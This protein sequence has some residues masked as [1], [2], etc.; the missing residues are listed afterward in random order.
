MGRNLATSRCG[1]CGHET[2]DLAYRAA[3][4]CPSHK[5]LANGY[6]WRK[7]QFLEEADVPYAFAGEHRLP[8]LCI[9]C[10]YW[11]VTT[12]DRADAELM[13][14][15]WMIQK[16]FEKIDFHINVS[17]GWDRIFVAPPE[18]DA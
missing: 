12:S 7:I 16:Y 4:L 10:G 13:A 18:D 2:Y 14:H 17:R 8:Y 3:R 1:A 9:L 15:V 5:R 6:C 11:H